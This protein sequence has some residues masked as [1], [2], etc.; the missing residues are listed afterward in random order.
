MK[1]QK[2]NNN[3]DDSQ[4]LKKLDSIIEQTKNENE[5]LKKLLEGLERM[6]K[7]VSEKNKTGKKKK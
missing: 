6:N 3:A 1:T 5:A 7:E 2:K 4:T